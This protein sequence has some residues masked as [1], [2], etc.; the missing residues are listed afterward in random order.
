[1]S[2]IKC[3]D[4]GKE[5]SSHAESCPHCGYP[6]NKTDD[7]LDEDSIVEREFNARTIAQFVSVGMVSL[8]GIGMIIAAIVYHG[9]DG[10]KIPQVTL[11]LIGM[12]IFMLLASVVGF[13]I[14]KWRWNVTH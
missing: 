11:F 5:I 12:G 10:E 4:C 13:F 3:P 2:L 8:M 7:F 14:A 9:P 1:M 6:L